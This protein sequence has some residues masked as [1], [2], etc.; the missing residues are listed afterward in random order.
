MPFN[1]T[2]RMME[3]HEISETIVKIRAGRFDVVHRE[4][5]G[6]DSSSEPSASAAAVGMGTGMGTS[7]NTYNLDDYRQDQAFDDGFQDGLDDVYAGKENIV[8]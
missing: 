7:T 5:F 2:Q 4:V 3:V 8:E 6:Q 1:A